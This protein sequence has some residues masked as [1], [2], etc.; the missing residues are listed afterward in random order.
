MLRI[1]IHIIL[2]VQFENH[3]LIH[4]MKDEHSAL[5]IRFCAS[6]LF[7]ERERSDGEMGEVK[8]KG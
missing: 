5:E 2:G 1:Y 6:L 8:E 4:Y 7:Y 3:C